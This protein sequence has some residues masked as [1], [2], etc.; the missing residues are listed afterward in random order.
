MGGAPS[1]SLGKSGNNLSPS[2]YYTR[3]KV[4]VEKSAASFV[5]A[6]HTHIFYH[7]LQRLTGRHVSNAGSITPSINPFLTTAP[8][9]AKMPSQFLVLSSLEGPR[10]ESSSVPN[11][12]AR[13]S[14]S[15]FARSPSRAAGNSSLSPFNAVRSPLANRQIPRWGDRP[16]AAVGA[17]R[18][19]SCRL[20]TPTRVRP[21]CSNSSLAR[22]R[23]TRELLRLS[24]KLTKH[25]CAHRV[26]K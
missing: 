18:A 20:H 11:A 2:Y 24:G 15:A 10:A 1:P 16:P 4:R 7:L 21:R 22:L 23:I 9:A 5:S 6:S 12:L 13:K 19:T 17:H 25:A 3:A 26:F 8:T 14:P